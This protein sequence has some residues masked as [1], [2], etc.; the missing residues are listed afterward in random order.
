MI[1]WTDNI[2]H[3]VWISSQKL[4]IFRIVIFCLMSDKP[5]IETDKKEEGTMDSA[6]TKKEEKA[7]EEE[8]GYERLMTQTE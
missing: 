4:N 5:Q 6:G 3:R 2:K 8:I 1:S 7:V